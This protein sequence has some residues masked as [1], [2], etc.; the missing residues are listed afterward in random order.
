[1]KTLTKILALVLVVAMI[2]C[3]FV[4]C[5]KDDKPV[6]DPNKTTDNNEETKAPEDE[7]TLVY[8]T[9][10]LSQKFSPFFAASAYDQDVVDLTTGGL[11]TTDREGN[12]VRNGIEGET[13]PYNGTDYTYYS[14]GNVEV[15]E[16]A[17]GSV[18]YNL[19]MRDDIVFSD[20]TPATIDDVIFGVYVLCDPTFDGGITLYGVPIE[21]VDE[22]RG[23]MTAKGDLIIAGGRDGESDAYT[24]EER[25]AYWAAIDAAGAE[26]VQGIVDYCCDAFGE[27]VSVADAM[28]AWGFEGLEADA[29]ND[30][31]WAML[32]EAYEGDVRTANEV[33]QGYVDLFEAMAEA[34]GDEMANYEKGVATGESAPN[35]KGVIKTGDYSMTIHTTEYDATAI[36]NM[37]LPIAP[38]HYY[39][40]PSQYDYDN[41]M[42]GFTKGDLSI[43]KAKSTQPMG[44]GPYTF[45]SYENGVVT[46]RANDSYFLGRP[47]IDNLLLQEST[48]ADYIPGIGKGTFDMAMPSIDDD[49]VA[50]LQAGNTNGELTGDVFTTKLVDYLGYGYIG[51]SADL[52]KVGDDSASQESK[53]LRNALTTLMAVRRDTV[54]NSYYGDRA[55]IIQYP[56][57]NTSWA[58]PRPADEGYENC[59]S[60]DVDGN[61]IYTEG[62][63]EEE[64]YDAALQAAIGYLKAAGYTWDDATGTFTAAPEGASMKYEILIPGD[65]TQ[66]HPAYGVAVGASEA[67]A[68]VGFTLQVNDVSG[69]V[70]NN[71]LEG[72][73]AELWA[74][75]WQATPDPDMYQVY[76][77][78]NAHGNGTNSNHYAIDDADLDQLILDGRASSDTAFRKATYKECF[79]IIMSWGVELPLYQ[80]KD[81][82]VVSTERVNADT[83]PQDMTPYWGWKAEIEKLEMN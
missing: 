19:T 10:A 72:N 70:W 56:I 82:T 51:V 68:T 80:R 15:V 40:D 44:C 66:D 17:D 12:I 61:P 81:C 1:M 54:I 67:L 53:Y 9:T 38:M 48:N 45:V 35:I 59:Y 21:G 31:A 24:A 28:A 50:A 29:T 79:D 47:K 58:A 16:N 11:L 78:S 20:G 57:S 65:G 52:V 30:D 60:R 25:D 14:M 8:A 37:G 63:T 36:Y 39:G 13:I 7:K 27:D 55:S 71:A 64:R 5:N 46:M 33:E 49:A 32:L 42:F 18:D 23:G 41:N 62:M 73:T 43:V 76:H 6:D 22:Y 3:L 77:S 69:D 34:L 2:A 74:A 26:M 83:L 4:G 75:A